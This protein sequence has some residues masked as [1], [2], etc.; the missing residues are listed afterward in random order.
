MRI[1]I[2]GTGIAGLVAARRLHAEHEIT[3]F[4]AADRLGGHTHTVEVRDGDAT[5]AIDT[6]FIVF[7]ARTYP[8]FLALLDELGVAY[9]PGPMSFSVRDEADGLEYN[10]TSLDGLFAQR[11]NLL[12]PRFWRMLRD[13]LRFYR[14]APAV[15]A[16]G[17]D[18]GDDDGDDDGETLGAYLERNR[19]SR[20]FVEQ[21]LVPMGAAV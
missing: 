17:G 3:V 7:N 12:R 18:D 8:G 1:A 10:G 20:A 11:R 15:L 2:V 21:H 16:R 6:G 14:E 4:E 9:Q 5:T 13:I 19:Y